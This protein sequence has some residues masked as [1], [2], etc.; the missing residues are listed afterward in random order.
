MGDHRFAAGKGGAGHGMMHEADMRKIAAHQEEDLRRR[1]GHRRP[2]QHHREQR[3]HALMR[4]HPAGGDRHLA[5]EQRA[6]QQ[7]DDAILCEQLFHRRLLRDQAGEPIIS[8]AG[9][10]G[11]VCGPDER[12]D[13]WCRRRGERRGE[14]MEQRRDP[15][16]ISYATEFD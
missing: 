16:R 3:Q 10:G 13:S 14:A 6:D 11:G 7:C 5:L 4:E 2:D 8:R 1:E 9:A 12:E 15:C